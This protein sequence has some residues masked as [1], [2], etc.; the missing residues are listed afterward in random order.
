MT[1][2]FLQTQGWARGRRGIALAAFLAL[3][4]SGCG[5]SK[6]QECDKCTSDDECAPA[7]LFCRPF[8]ED[9]STRCA[10][11]KGETLCRTPLF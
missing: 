2:L 9:G 11:G 7:G 4:V 10:S 8:P 5:S 6:G 1:S 3:V